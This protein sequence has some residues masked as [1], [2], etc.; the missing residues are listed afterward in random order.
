MT[1]PA[2][3]QID[4]LRRQLEYHNHL[5]YVE[6][7][8]EISDSEYDRLYAEL[9]ALEQQ[10][11]EFAD[12][13]SPTNKVGGAVSSAFATYPHGVRMLSL[14]N[15]YSAEDLRAYHQRIVKA[16]GTDAVEYL[17]E[18]KIDGVGISIR[19]E[20]GLLVRALTRGDGETGEDVTENV[21][22]IKSIPLRLQGDNLPE[23]WEVRGEIFM[24][25][26]M[27][28]ALNRQREALGETPFANPR[29]TTAGTLKMLDSNVV[30]T[31][32][33]DAVFYSLGEYRGRDISS[34]VGLLEETR[35]LGLKVPPFAEVC[36]GVDQV[37]DAIE[38]LN[39]RRQSFG[40]ELDGA[41]VKV[42]S[43][44]L[45]ESL[46]FT[47]KSPRW[48]I[49]YKYEAEKA[50]TRLKAVTIQ[51][52]RTGVLTPVAELEPVHLSGTTV[53]RATLHNFDEIKRK[54]IRV[55]DVV[56]IEKAGEIIPAVLRAL[57]S[58]RSGAERVIELPER[59]PGCGAAT[60]R[61]DDEV[62]V[63]C[64][65]PECPPQVKGRLIHFAGR[66]AMDIETLGTAV[67]EVMVDEGIITTPA[68]IYEISDEHV[69]HLTGIDGFGEKSVSK[70]LESIEKS[71]DNPPWRLVFGLG[72]RHIGAKASRLLI[73]AF[74]SIDALAA[75]SEEEL[76]AVPDIGG[77][78]AESVRL[79]FSHEKNRR[80]L[81]RLKR[82]GVCT[83][84]QE[85]A[86]VESAFT[87]KTCVLTGTLETMTRGEAGEILSSLGAN[88]S[89]SV[90]K[91]TDFVIA[92]PGAGSKLTKAEKLGVTVLSE[93]EFLG[94]V[95]RNPA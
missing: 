75:A 86:V 66:G 16:M 34:Q 11:P 83:V 56:E 74:G 73:D 61:S 24:P 1:T 95:G 40:Y 5:Y 33:L 27:F 53:G 21:R 57:V 58:E 62:A 54:D 63:R 6:A 43:R 46:G 45:Q 10:H 76:T 18:P 90:S 67:V 3:D 17:V 23:V 69:K 41:V 70:L 79:F 4:R 48:A 35:R 30:A 12:P 78:M 44:E 36:I 15:T 22:T 25:V 50:I 85:T 39:Q 91:K 59:C 8:P 64:I 71:K 88:V 20:S 60:V 37:L 52:G 80:L 14:D 87:G 7:S 29:N 89:S 65:D 9:I 93:S 13:N 55:G 32:P 81:E 42:N 84:A 38:T 51:V 19:Y 49:A 94:A 68:D 47:A 31:R 77:V 28:Q 26:A 72:I 82:S 92:G 2:R